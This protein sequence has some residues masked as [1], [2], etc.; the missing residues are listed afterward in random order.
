MRKI[1]ITLMTALLAMLAPAQELPQFNVDDYVGWHYNNPGVPLN[2]DNISDGRVVLYV[3]SAKKALTL[4]SPEFNCQDIDSIA[5]S[6]QWYTGTF[7]HSDFD[8]SLTALT[9]VIDDS[10]GEPVDSVTCEPT[11]TGS[12]RTLHLRLAVPQGLETCRLRFV[13]WKGTLISSGAI[14]R[15][16]ISAVEAAPHGNVM[17]GDVDGDGII[18]IGDA[19]E[20]IDYLL[21]GPES[22]ANTDASDLDGEGVITIADVTAI[23]DMILYGH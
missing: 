2:A 7:Y 4:T 21:F 11:T 9:M 20:L 12:L 23:I 10:T 14:K 15:A 16:D 18:T 1:F 8:L 5:A 6:V 19:T 22:N 17:L 3:N 13:S